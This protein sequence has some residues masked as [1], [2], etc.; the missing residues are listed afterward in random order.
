[1]RVFLFLRLFLC[2]V[3]C[4]FSLRIC[5]SGWA[6]SEKLICY[7]LVVLSRPHVLSTLKIFLALYC[8]PYQH[9]IG[10]DWKFSCCSV[11]VGEEFRFYF[12]ESVFLIDSIHRVF[13]HGLLQSGL[14]YLILSIPVLE[15]YVMANS[16]LAVT[17]QHWS[18]S[19]W[20]FRWNSVCPHFRK[21]INLIS[22]QFLNWT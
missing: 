11:W 18:P 22:S 9:Y 20:K 6:S 4:S 3:F 7:K 15:A 13:A 16:W 8:C 19:A 17:T 5:I 21:L 1:M 14:T 2:L 12:F 10:I